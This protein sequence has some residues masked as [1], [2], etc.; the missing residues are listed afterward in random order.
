MN[1]IFRRYTYTVWQMAII[2]VAVAAIAMI[3]GAYLSSFVLDTLWLFIAMWAIT[4]GYILWLTY[5]KNSPT[6]R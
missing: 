1:R 5:K 4:A 2:K 3:A 6:E